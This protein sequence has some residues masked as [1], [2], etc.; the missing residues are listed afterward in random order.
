MM[1]AAGEDDVGL[2]HKLARL[3]GETGNPAEGI[4]TLRYLKGRSNKAGSG[5]TAILRAKLLEQSG[6]LEE[7]L[8]S[9]R[10]ASRS[11]EY[12]DVAAVE[13]ARIDAESGRCRRASGVLWG[14]LM[15][16]SG[17]KQFT[18][19]RPYLALARF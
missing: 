11:P 15:T 3:Y 9:L 8:V 6:D 4:R 18:D 17:Q 2:V 14:K 13:I 12:R 5:E 19:P 7:A 10:R 1:L 16:P